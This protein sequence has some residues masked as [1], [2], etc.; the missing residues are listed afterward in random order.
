VDHAALV[1]PE[2]TKAS[3]VH[4]DHKVMQV[5]RDLKVNAA[6]LDTR[7]FKI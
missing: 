7:D 4:K 6:P 1:D 2:V 3:S 5:P